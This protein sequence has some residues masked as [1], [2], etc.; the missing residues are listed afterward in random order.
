MSVG[1]E[2]GN[3][4]FEIPLNAKSQAVSH[5]CKIGCDLSQKAIADYKSQT[6]WLLLR[7]P[8]RSRV[9]L[10]MVANHVRLAPGATDVL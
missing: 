7:G 5:Y 8:E 2:I 4:G 9:T 6:A 3:L 1:F 10:R